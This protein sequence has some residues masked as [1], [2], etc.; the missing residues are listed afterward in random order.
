MQLTAPEQQFHG[1]TA[2]KIL[3]VE[4][5]K[6]Q[7]TECSRSAKMYLAKHRTLSQGTKQCNRLWNR[8][9]QK[10]TASGRRV[11]P[12]SKQLFS[13][14]YM[15]SIATLPFFMVLFPVWFDN[16]IDVLYLSYIQCMID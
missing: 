10:T 4:I 13:Y 16:L 3:F 2:T 11:K 1:K 14:L 8:S 15:W 9:Q 5:K 7:K 12:E 6:H